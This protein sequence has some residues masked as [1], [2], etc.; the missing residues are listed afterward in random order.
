MDSN[1][2][3]LIETNEF[4]TPITQELLDQYPKEVQEQFYT[5]INN[6][7]F[8]KRL[9]SPYRLRAKDLPRDENGRIKVDIV[10]PHIL[11][12]MDYFREAALTFLKIGKYTKLRPNA[13]PTSA[14]YKWAYREV[15]RIWFGMTRESDGEWIS[16][17]MY[18]YLNYMPMTISQRAKGSKKKTNRIE[19][20]PRSWEGAYLWF[21]YLNQAKHGGLYDENGGKNALQIA[22]RGASKSYSCASML[23]RL[24][25]CGNSAEE[26]DKIVGV[27]LAATKEALIKDGTLNKFETCIDLCAEHTQWP[28]ERLLS[29]LDKMNWEMGYKDPGSDI[30]KGSKNKIQG[31]AVDKSPE[32]ARGKRATAIIYEEI[33]AFKK[34]LTAWG[35]NEPSVCE[36][37]FVW[38]T[39]IG[40]GTGGS[41]GSDFY[42]ILEMLYNPKGYRVYPLPNVYD[43]GSSGDKFTIFFFGA[44][45][46]REG[47]YNHNGVSD[48]VGSILNILNSRFIIKYNSTDPNRLMNAIAERPLTIQEAIMKK[49]AAYFPVAQLTERLNQIDNDPQFYDD[50]YTG[51]MSIKDNE[52]VFIPKQVNIIRS[53]PHK[54]NKLDGGIEIFV[55]PQK[56]ADKKVFGNR[57]I[58]GTDPV[59]DDEAGTMSLQSTWIFDTWTDAIVAEYTGRPLYVESYYEQLRLLLLFYNANNHYENNKKGL[60]AYFSRMNSLYLLA[61][62][63]DFLKDKDMIKGSP[64]GNKSK[65][66]NATAP[67]NKYARL[68]IRN[69][70]LSPVTVIV[71]DENGNESTMTI[72][73]LY[74]LKSRALIQELIQWC[75]EGNFDRVSAF[76]AMILLRE[77]RI[78]Q[79]GGVVDGDKIT[80]AGAKYLGN[81]AYFDKNYKKD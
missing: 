34:F 78:I 10:N 1:S 36:G 24:F 39:Q 54:D 55:M 15:E 32:K 72:S 56:G 6:V 35:V 3:V 70:L 45:L 51:M 81:D 16:G 17:E 2:K 60:Y 73:R 27:I 74:T 64:I 5:Y 50:V 31:V 67:I 25:V 53:F 75:S 38:G 62:T 7:I 76:G 23:A 40:I 69:Y 58:A 42:G 79:Y 47:H 20:F 41:E 52:V 71:K 48:V 37:D 49:D 30:K 46:N 63:L 13:N 11:E 14:Y 18:F 65:G 66:F 21:H 33:G 57:Y 59:D 29:S 77:S 61:D 44:Y 28:S 12:D 43:K 80:K 19:S 9:I 22:T 68:L 4:Q 8:I 26:Q